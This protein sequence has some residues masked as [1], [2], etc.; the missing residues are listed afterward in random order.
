MFLIFFLKKYYLVKVVE[1]LLGRGADANAKDQH[2]VTGLV[3]AAGRG[4]EE[5]VA[6]MLEAN[7]RW[8]KGDKKYLS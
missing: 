3:W 4:H 5:V 6:A 1:E 2:H 8:K 7:A